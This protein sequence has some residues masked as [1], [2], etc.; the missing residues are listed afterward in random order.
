LLP[1][2]NSKGKRGFLFL[3]SLDKIDNKIISMLLED[4]RTS[5]SAIAHEVNLTDVAI[6]KRFER[7]KRKG[8][9]NSITIIE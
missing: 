9:I 5:F 3:E 8:I 1:C 7:L 6:K 2:L 4:G